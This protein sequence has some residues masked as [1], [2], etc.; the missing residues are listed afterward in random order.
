MKKNICLLC[1]S[2]LFLSSCSSDSN[3]STASQDDVLVK[4]VWTDDNPYPNHFIYNGKKI[5][6][7]N[8]NGEEKS[9]TYTGNLI[10]KIQT[11]N[12]GNGL[13]YGLRMEDLFTYDASERLTE[14]VFKSI[15]DANN[16][17]HTITTTFVYNSN[18]TISAVK[19]IGYPTLAF[20]YVAETRLIH[21]SGT[22]VISEDTSV[23]DTT[24]SFVY[25]YITNYN[26]DNKNNPFKNV[27][28]YHEI[29][30]AEEYVFCFEHL[31]YLHNIVATQQIPNIGDMITATYTYN[32][33]NFPLTAVESSVSEPGFQTT[34][35]YLYY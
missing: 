29:A 3:Q 27:I 28:G 31:R 17:D 23:Y 8:C 10:T 30:L 14:H 16:V 24:G 7:A 4:E 21:L 18:N 33:L 26:Y 5:V 6:S 2:L 20:S 1:L 12:N 19:T 35:N 25:S 34:T 15:P 22:T 9:Y 32:S 13:G 11:F